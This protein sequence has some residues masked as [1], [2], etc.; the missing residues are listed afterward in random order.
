MDTSLTHAQELDHHDP[1]APYRH[2]FVTA[3]PDLIYLDG[4]SLG[5][6]PHATIPAAT[7]LINH[8]WGN[9]LIRSWNEAG[10]WQAPERIGAKIAPLIGAQ[11]DEVIVADS[12]SVN[13][14]KLAVAALRYQ[15]G[16][17]QIIT[18][19]LNFPSDIYI[20]QGVIDLLGNHHTLTISPSPDDIYGA[21]IPAA[22]TPDTALLTLS[23]TAFKSGFVY[24]MAAINTAAH[25]AGALTL[26]DLSHSV[27]ALQVNLNDSNADL[28]I[29]CTYKYLNG[30]PGAPAFIYI[31]R[32]LQ[33]KLFNPITGWAG[34]H[35]PFN[36]SLDYQ[37]APGLRRFLTG[38][39]PVTSL[40]LIEPGLDLMLEAGLA[41]LQAKSQQQTAYLI[42]LWRAWLEPLGFTLN[43]PLEPDQRGSHVSLGHPEG[44]RIN[45]TLIEDLNV[46]PDFRAPDNIRLGIAPLYTSFEHIHQ[47][48]DRMRRCV[49]DKLYLKYDAQRPTVT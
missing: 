10:W 34:Q 29:G 8:Q 4:N 9:R 41:N 3:D 24:D 16:R 42:S 46:L 37:P 47:A 19:N 31:R 5:R 28:A 14:F 32:D 22:L 12:T 30:G 11:P 18:D 45:R 25:D 38:T 23:H 36:F 35:N 33:D 43:T 1:L 27:G 49:T 21:D 13:L 48:L 44:W 17:S 7:Q 2:Q 15:N 39:M 26:W 40:A 20:L 6:L